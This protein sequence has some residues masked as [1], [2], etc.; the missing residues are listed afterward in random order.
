M[1]LFLSRERS[2]VWGKTNAMTSLLKTGERGK[3]TPTGKDR[4]TKIYVAR[5]RSGV[6]RLRRWYGPGEY[7]KGR[8]C[9]QE[10]KNV[11]NLEAAG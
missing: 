5:G 11:T 4:Q 2:P 9:A 7:R 10:G 6:P 1:Q 3:A 8:S